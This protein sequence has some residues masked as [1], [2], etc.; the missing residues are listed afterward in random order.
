LHEN[1]KVSFDVK[2]GPKGKQS[3]NIKPAWKRRIFESDDARSVWH[4][5]FKVGQER[6][7]KSAAGGTKHGA[8][9]QPEALHA[10]AN[11]FIAFA[12]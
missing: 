12:D 10:N 2:M 8:W 4:R 1:Q 9:H 6:L 7:V 5:I 3:A 11:R